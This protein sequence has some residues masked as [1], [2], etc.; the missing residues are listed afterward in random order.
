MNK[1][2]SKSSPENRLQ[3]KVDRWGGVPLISLGYFIGLYSLQGSIGH[4]I[5]LYI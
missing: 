5:D 3:S 4:I 2:F 1:T